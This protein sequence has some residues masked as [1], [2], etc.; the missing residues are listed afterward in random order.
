MTKKH[1]V[2]GIG[3]PLLDIIVNVDE[4]V[5]QE[6]GLEKGEMKLTSKEESEKIL[7]HIREHEKDVISGGSV[8]N[9]ISGTSL[10]GNKSILLGIIGDDEHG[11][12]YEKQTRDDGVYSMLH[13]HGDDATGHAVI[14][15]TPDGE[16]TMATHLGAAASM[17]DHHILD[18]EIK[19]GKFLHIE[20]YQLEDPLTREA[21]FQAMDTAKNN[22]IKVGLDLSDPWLIDRTG[23]LFKDVVDKYADVVFAN[24][25]EAVKFTGLN[26]IDAVHSIADMCDTAV[27][28]LGKKGSLIKSDGK[29]YKINPHSIEVV[30]TNGAGD[31]YAAGV[32][33]GIVNDLCLHET[34]KIASH[35]A[36][37]VV[38]SPGAR[39]DKMHHGEIEKYR[40]K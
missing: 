38:A 20:A 23:D 21:M 27:V 5:L 17:R 13:R 9:T 7:E 11:E 3:S 10:V 37:L 35:M 33:H 36:A 22:G 12:I 8:A 40:I 39:M 31:M 18:D 28:K 6:L 29:L 1:D 26:E 19:K 25:D 32:I 2:V 15:V 16:R 14:F 4:E 34:G 30:N 24:E